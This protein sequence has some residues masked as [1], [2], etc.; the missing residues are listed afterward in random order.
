MMNSESHRQF[1]LAAAGIRMW[2][3]KR[4]LP[5]A[6]PSPDYQFTADEAPEPDALNSEP[7][8]VAT[9]VVRAKPAKAAPPAPV[10]PRSVDLQ[11][12]MSPQSAPAEP[13]VEEGTS[14]PESEEVTAPIASEARPT[15]HAN[16]A[17]WVT[18]AFVLISQWSDDASERLQD[19]LARNLLSALGQS[20][21]GERSVLRWPVFRNPNIP[22]NSPEDF[23][24]V[25]SRSLSSCQERSIIL[26][27]AL[28]REQQEQR[29][30]CLQAALPQ[31]GVD[32]PCS[33]AEIAA[34]PAHKRDLWNALK[35]RYT[36]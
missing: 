32:F 17:L 15:I 23:Q 7:E 29:E 30:H 36:L 35:S 8:A 1:Y 27:G 13:R 26:L 24:Q 9:P 3:A 2:Y 10:R 21:I 18:E 34:T 22:G 33:L 28:S 16:L 11:S 12:L 25:L 20:D 5:G 31:V 19:T 6:A 4:P 14:A